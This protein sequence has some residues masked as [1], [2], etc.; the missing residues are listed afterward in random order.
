MSWFW[1]IVGLVIG[2]PIGAVVFYFAMLYAF[3]TSGWMR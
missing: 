1:L 2:V 3:Y